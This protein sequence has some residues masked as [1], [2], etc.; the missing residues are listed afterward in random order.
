MKKYESKIITFLCKWCTYVGADLA[1]TSRL[2]FSQNAVPI[3]VMCSDRV[4]SSFV[5]DAFAKGAD[6]VLAG[7]CHPGDYQYAQGN[8]KTL[9]RVKLLK[10]LLKDMR[11]EEER[12]KLEWISA[13]EGNKFRE[14]VN[15]MIIKIKEIESSPLKSEE[16]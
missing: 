2:K 8:H 1:G 4:D 11:L 7:D 16:S 15:D 9:R 12:L 3:W 6:G 5:F 13:S 10:M 14:G